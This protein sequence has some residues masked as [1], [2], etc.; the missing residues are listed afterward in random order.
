MFMLNIDA[1]IIIFEFALHD[2]NFLD[3]LLGTLHVRCVFSVSLQDSHINWSI[4]TCSLQQLWF[5]RL[6]FNKQ[7]WLPRKESKKP[8]AFKGLSFVVIGSQL[9]LPPQSLKMPYM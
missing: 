6:L 5:L 9:L 7:M 1:Y 3:F 8:D 4:Y 2:I